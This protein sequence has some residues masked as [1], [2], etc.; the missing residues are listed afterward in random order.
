MELVGPSKRRFAGI[1]IHMFWCVGLFLETGLAYGIREWSYLQMAIATP[2]APMA[3]LY[4]VLLPESARWLIQRGRTQEAA[5]I[6]QQ[7]ARKNGVTLTE[8]AQNLNDL[9]VE[10]KEQSIWL[11]FT[12]R[13]LL[14]RS[15]IVFFNWFVA[16][17]VYYGLSLNVGDLSGNIYLNFFLSAVVE[18]LSY[19]FLLALL[20]VTGRKVMQCF[21]MVLGGAACIA[22]IF[23]VLYGSDS[24]AWVTVVLSQTGKFG[25]SAAFI[26]IYVYTAEIFPTVMRNSAIG[27]CSICARLGGILAPYIGDLDDLLEKDLGIALPLLIFGGLSVAAGLLVLLLP[28]TSNKVLPDTIEDAKHFG[29]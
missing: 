25:A 19:F 18:L 3:L 7:V 22:A 14:T 28:E 20:D 16:S 24:I 1:I 2:S 17:M 21:S 4:I 10:T 8:K 15:L 29:K 11:M 6:I 9:E 27:L 5:Q 23:P 26:V 13:T 12:H